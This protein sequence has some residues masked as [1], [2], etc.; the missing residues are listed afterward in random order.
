MTYSDSNSAKILK[1]FGSKLAVGRMAYEAG[2]FSQALR[3]FSSAL[4]LANDKALDDDLKGCALLG[5]AK[6]TAALGN[7]EQAKQF[8]NQALI[9]HESDEGSLVEEAE[10]YHQ[11]SLIYWRSGNTQMARQIANKSWELACN[12][13]KTPDELKAKLLKHFAIL[14]EQEGLADECESYL[15]KAME[16]IESSHQLG[17]QSSI[18]GDVLLVKVLLLVEQNRFEEAAELYPQ[19]LQIVETNRGI[20]HPRV[21]EVIDIFSEIDKEVRSGSSAQLAL[22]GVQ[23][24]N[25][26]G[27]V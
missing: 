19:A 25:K 1:N 24:K 18:Y 5:A 12:D 6:S 21:K 16:F 9:I 3:H 27:I 23:R 15:D 10:D 11:L 8:L 4:Q 7:F 13:P 2:Y 14:A 22:N 20:A 26:H 17:K